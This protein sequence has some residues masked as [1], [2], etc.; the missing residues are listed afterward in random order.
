VRQEKEFDYDRIQKIHDR[1]DYHKDPDKMA[2]K[3]KSARFDLKDS[4][5]YLGDDVLSTELSDNGDLDVYR[6]YKLMFHQEQLTV[7]KLEEQQA[8]LK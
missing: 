4:P 2:D 7:E 1:V 5:Y 3:K 8:A 6:K